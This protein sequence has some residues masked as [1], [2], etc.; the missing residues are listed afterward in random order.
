MNN[1]P[2][3]ATIIPV[4]VLQLTLFIVALTSILRKPLPL[5]SKWKWVPLLFVN[6]IGPVI[7][8][9]VGSRSLNKKAAMLQK[10]S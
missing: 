7:Y 6:V 1:K 9:A 3:P 4:I 5:S 8:F 10:E 2:N